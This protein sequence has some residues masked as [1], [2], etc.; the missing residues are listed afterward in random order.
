ME[1]SQNCKNVAIS[2]LNGVNGVLKSRPRGSHPYIYEDQIESPTVAT[3]LFGSSREH[4]QP[5][6]RIHRAYPPPPHHSAFSA[7]VRPSTMR[8]STAKLLLVSAISPQLN[9]ATRL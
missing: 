8:D 6:A 5:V 7:S 4:E 9:L 2:S 1:F 3:E